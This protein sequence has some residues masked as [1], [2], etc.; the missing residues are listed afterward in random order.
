MSLCNLEA[1]DTSHTGRFRGTLSR[2]TSLRRIVSMDQKARSAEKGLEET[3]SSALQVA[4]GEL[5]QI[6]HEVDEISRILKSDCP[7]ASTLRAA[8]HPAV[9]CA[10]KQA[11]LDRELRRLALT[12][13]LTSLYNRRGFFAAA[14][15]QLKLAR[16]NG[17]GLLLLFCDL[18]G[19]K[20]INDSFGHGEGDL[21]LVRVADALEQTFRASDVLARL[22]GDEFVI[23]ALED[24]AQTQ[25][26][27]LQRLKKSLKKQ[28][29]G[30]SRYGLS[31]SVGVAR[32]DPKRAVTLGEL[33]AQA[34]KAMYEQKQI[35]R[36]LALETSAR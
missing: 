2:Q 21:A 19:L 16:R 9:W 10:V 25:D 33:M 23:L 6:L 28:S 30:E 12:D 5:G 29:S 20:K 27:V 24:S 3:L 36:T 18:D 14:T 22:G 4:D 31:L 7:D 13:D 34:D 15:Q 35:A 17:Q 11:L 26:I 32:F 1:A 8:V